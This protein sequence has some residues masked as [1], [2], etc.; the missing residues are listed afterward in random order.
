MAEPAVDFDSLIL[1][2][3]ASSKDQI[4]ELL[5]NAF[6]RRFDACWP[7]KDA[8]DA[9]AA[10]LALESPEEATKLMKAVSGLVKVCLGSG[11]SILTSGYRL[12]QPCFSDSNNYEETSGSGA[13]WNTENS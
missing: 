2:L 1:L 3:K 6:E 12:R 11:P 13:I 8:V 4:R 10:S 7:Q 9:L 5:V